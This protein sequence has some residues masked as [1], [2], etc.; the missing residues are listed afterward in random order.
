MHLEHLKGEFLRMLEKSAVM[1]KMVGMSKDENPMWLQLQAPIHGEE[2]PPSL[3]FKSSQCPV[4]MSIACSEE[5]I[6]IVDRDYNSAYKYFRMLKYEYLE[7][8]HLDLYKE[9]RSY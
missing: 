9:I 4:W 5:D 6:N 2:G 8:H 7:E 1:Y 3:L